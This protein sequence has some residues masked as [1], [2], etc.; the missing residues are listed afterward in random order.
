MSQS[1]DDSS[2]VTGRDIKVPDRELI[3]RVRNITSGHVWSIY[4]DGWDIDGFGEDNIISN[5]LHRVPQ[6]ANG[7]VSEKS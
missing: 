7:T 2:G 6:L 4:N 1:N 3:F 5:F